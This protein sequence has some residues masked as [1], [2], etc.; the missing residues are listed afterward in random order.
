MYI[1]LFPSGNTSVDPCFFHYISAF[2]CTVEMQFF[3]SRSC[4][5][6]SRRERIG[7]NP[8]IVLISSRGSSLFFGNASFIGLQDLVCNRRDLPPEPAPRSLREPFSGSSPVS[9]EPKRFLSSLFPSIRPFPSEVLFF[10]GPFPFL[11]LV[12]EKR[13]SLGQTRPFFFFLPHRM[14][15]PSESNKSFHSGFPL[16][17]LPRQKR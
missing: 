12:I 3:F 15:S 7:R 2:L 8:R 1:A 9:I 14:E 5:F 4:H 6:P 10:N 13:T 11:R 17:S 16:F